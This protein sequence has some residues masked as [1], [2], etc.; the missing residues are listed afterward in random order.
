M[1]PSPC[2]RTITLQMEYCYVFD[3]PKDR[4]TISKLSYQI[5]PKKAAFLVDVFDYIISKTNRGKIFC[6]LSYYQLEKFRIRDSMII[7]EDTK[8]F[9]PL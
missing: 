8:I 9:A 5:Y 3:N 4:S 6:D 2:V 7:T 1:F